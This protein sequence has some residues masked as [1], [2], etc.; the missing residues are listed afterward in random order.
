MFTH[1]Y[2]RTPLFKK[3]MNRSKAVSKIIHLKEVEVVYIIT[4]RTS[5]DFDLQCLVVDL[6]PLQSFTSVL[7]S[8]YDFIPFEL[9]SAPFKFN[10]RDYRYKTSQTYDRPVIIYNYLNEETISS[11]YVPDVLKAL[12]EQASY[13]NTLV[14]KLVNVDM[15]DYFFT[16]KLESWA[17]T[18]RVVIFDRDMPGLKHVMWQNVSMLFPPGCI[19]G[20]S[21]ADAY[22]KCFPGPRDLVAI[23][24]NCAGSL[25][26]AMTKCFQPIQEI[27]KNNF[28][29]AVHLLIWYF[30]QVLGNKDI[31]KLLVKEYISEWPAVKRS[32]PFPK[33]YNVPFML[34][35]RTVPT[36]KTP[37]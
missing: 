28:K 20:K 1:R 35:P 5:F 15:L 10:E 24:M 17:Y 22:K 27:R 4:T 31:I 32:F 36:R 14:I 25:N 3:K 19:F 6:F 11:V 34:H 29:H 9:A 26:A 37:R 12:S 30:L 13:I 33:G 16:L 8:F 2:L 21:P 7:P 18:A 23:N